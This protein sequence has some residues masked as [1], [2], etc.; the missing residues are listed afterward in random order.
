MV[1]I[2]QFDSEFILCSHRQIK[3]PFDACFAIER[4]LAGTYLL[5]LGVSVRSNGEDE[6][7][8]GSSEVE[9]SKDVVCTLPHIPIDFDTLDMLLVHSIRW[10]VGFVVANRR[11]TEQRFVGS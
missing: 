6:F 10:C 9:H 2:I 11:R 3:S 7:V 1:A 8:F 4:V 5:L